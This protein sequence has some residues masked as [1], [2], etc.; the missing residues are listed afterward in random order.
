MP[1]HIEQIRR[2]I[3]ACFSQHAGY[4]QTITAVAARAGKDNKTGVGIPSGLQLTDN[5][6]T[7][8][9]HQIDGGD[10]LMVYRVSVKLTKLS[11]S[12]YLHFGRLLRTR[13]YDKRR[14]MR[15]PNIFD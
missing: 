13:A 5:S 14:R 15:V 8:T 1:R 9:L 11:A 12:E 10:G 2:N 6:T 7:G 3:I 4:S